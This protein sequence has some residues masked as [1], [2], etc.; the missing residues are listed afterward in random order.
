MSLAGKI[1]KNTGIKYA[2]SIANIIF[3]ALAGYV[4]LRYLTVPQFGAFA[5]ALSFAWVVLP[6]IDLGISQVVVADAAGYF[7]RKEMDKVKRLFRGFTFLKLFFGAIVAIAGLIFSF[8]LKYDAQ[9]ILLLRLSAIFVFIQC[10]RSIVITV[11][12]SFS[13]FFYS[14]VLNILESFFKLA[15]IFVFIFL[16]KMQAEGVILSYIFSTFLAIVFSLPFF[17]KVIL[18]FRKI[19]TSPEPIFKKL[20]FEHGKFQAFSQPIK[21]L[22][23]NFQLW[24]IG[25]SLNTS[26][27]GL[28]RLASQLFNY[29]SLLPAVS[30]SVL[31]PIFSEEMGS[32]PGKTGFIVQRVSKYLFWLSVPLTLGGFFAVPPVLYFLFGTKYNA[33]MPVFYMM[34][35]SL[36]AI[37]LGTSLRPA[38]FAFKDQKTILKI[39]LWTIFVSYPIAILCSLRWGLLGFSVVAPVS[40]ASSLFFRIYYLRKRIS[41]PIFTVKSFFSFD[42]YDSLLARR[43]FFAIKNKKLI[44]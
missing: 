40:A 9:F 32:R 15:A 35:I 24:Y 17:I 8:F 27:V 13:R 41:G 26:A 37:A 33:A 1:G 12:E 6:W 29:I 21:A 28:Y 30:E 38:F 18:P 22:S 34:L 36:P 20:I 16:L 10:V 19:I 39:H 7:G 44:S 14:A 11:F 25:W 3:G 42:R 31:M 5:L 43:I 2:Q 4:T 23:D